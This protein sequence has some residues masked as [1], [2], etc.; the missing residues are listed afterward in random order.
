MARRTPP[1]RRRTRGPVIDTHARWF[2]PEW[3]ALLEREGGGHGAQ[4]GRNS[5]GETT[6][7]LPGVALVSSFPADMI[8]LDVLLPHAGGTFPWLIGRYDNGCAREGNL[9]RLLEL[10]ES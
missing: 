3:V 10:Q 2:A 8:G 9:R 4:M 5:R 1:A 6:I 7:R